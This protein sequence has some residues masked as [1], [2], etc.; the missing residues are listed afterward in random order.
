MIYPSIDTLLDKVES[1]YSLC[2]VS[3]KRAHEL[4]AEQNPMLKTY[5][6]PKYVGQALE[7]ITDDK[8]VI[9]EGGKQSEHT[10]A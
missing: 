3:S 9:S 1:K 5:Q 6:S 2:S 10:E 8:L 4:Q 7:E